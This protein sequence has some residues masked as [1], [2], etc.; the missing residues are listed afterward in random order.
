MKTGW[1]SARSTSFDVSLLLTLGLLLVIGITTGCGSSGYTPPPPPPPPSETS[2]TVLLSG[3]ANDQVT[4]FYIEFQTLTLTSQSGKTVS[5]L[6]S[7]Q[8]AEFM[9]INGGLEP[10]TTVAVPPAIYTS[11]AVTVGAATF[12][13]YTAGSG[14][15]DGNI[16]QGSTVSLPSPITVTGGSMALVLN[17]LVSDSVVDFPTCATSQ[18][19]ASVTPTFNL[20]PI[21]LST[22]PTNSGN[23]K[24][25]G[26]NA[27]VASVGAAGSTLTLTV[28]AFSGLGLGPQT[29]TLSTS[30]TSATLFQGISGASAL[31]PGMFVDLDGAVQS[32]GS[33][34]ATRIE[35]IDA[36]AMYETTGPL[37]AF[38]NSPSFLSLGMDS[39]TELFNGQG[40]YSYDP[41]FLFPNAMFKISSQMA[42]LGNLPFVSSFNASN[43]VAGQNVDV[44]S[45]TISPNTEGIAPSAN[46]VTLI[47]QT[48]DGT[49]V[50][51]LPQGN[52]VDYTVSLASYDLFPTLAGVPGP[53]TVLSDP[54]QVEV[55]I[56]S[57]TQ[58]MNTQSLAVGSTLR[59]YGLVFNDNGILRMDC[60]QVNDGVAL[61]PPSSSSNS[62]NILPP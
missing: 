54:S 11:A 31:S 56:D 26:L 59:F 42:N 32:D 22:S 61:T 20:A 38:D 39:R 49:I 10:L 25:S 57:N 35:L 30:S 34:L 44:T 14:W 16:T 50:A 17:M 51:S 19:N 43:A 7:P 4:D 3:T 9:H 48:I 60:A 46:T 13:C 29:R 2:V 33:L 27:V 6:S 5:L 36:S 28:P 37:L 1:S 8:P 12:Y 40:S 58:E 62:G 53:T 23:G 15:Q 24:V 18:L 52:F 47:P 45:Q 55:Y 21:G 41:G